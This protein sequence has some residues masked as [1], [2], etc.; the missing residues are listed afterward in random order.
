MGL[1]P[2]HQG[3]YAAEGPGHHG[4]PGCSEGSR[5]RRSNTSP[6]T[7]CDDVGMTDNALSSPS[8]PTA[9]DEVAVIASDLIRIDT[10][11]PGDHSGPGERAAAEHV[12]GLL[13]EVGLEPNVLESHP[14][15]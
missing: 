14:K 15:R 10:T 12:A 3:H 2:G 4:R 13:A 6:G 7:W 1:W 11:N 5:G 8:G 9:Q